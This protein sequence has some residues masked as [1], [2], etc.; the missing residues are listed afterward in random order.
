MVVEL[1]CQTEGC[2]TKNLSFVVVSIMMSEDRSS[3]K[4]RLEMR[5]VVM[6]RESTD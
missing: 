4:K 3:F 1:Y 5:I 6:S 2:G